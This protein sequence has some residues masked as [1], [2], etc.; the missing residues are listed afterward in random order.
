MRG[1]WTRSSRQLN[2]DG[3]HVNV[4]INNHGKFS[5]FSDEEWAFNPFNVAN[6]GFLEIPEEFFTDERAAASYLKLM[7]YM[8]SRWGYSPNV[9]AWQVW[10]ELNLTG[11]KKD[12]VENYRRKE[13]VEWHRRMCA[14]IKKMDINAHMIS[15]HVSS[16]YGAQNKEIVQLP[17]L[18]F[19]SV[20]AYYDNPDPLHIVDLLKSTAEFNNG[21]AKPVLVTEFGGTSYA[22]RL[23]FLSDTLHAG[24]WSS[25]CTPVSGTPLFW[26]WQLIEEEDFYPEYTP[27]ANFMRN[28]DPRDPS[29]KMDNLNI[30][31]T[32]DGV[33]LKA[34]CL[35]NNRRARG[36]IYRCADFSSIDPGGQAI[37]SNVVAALPKVSNGNYSIEFYD[38]RT[39]TPVTK[40]ETEVTNE[41]LNL[42]VP[43]FARDI[44]FKASRQGR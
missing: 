32:I 19:A 43:A 37:T 28:E 2:D 3:I 29:L 16:D 33:E 13:V 25:T 42:N 18:D 11:S 9:F 4:V 24:L 5:T 23:R 1:N 12:G 10:S 17:E 34:I 40:V 39:G 41:V 38:T 8:I 27:I 20:D 36:W 26:W 15:T 30:S 22:Q 44:A 6:G 35:R 21:F 7:R 14:A 31:R